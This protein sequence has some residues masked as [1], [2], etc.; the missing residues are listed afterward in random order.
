M[1]YLKWLFSHRWQVITAILALILGSRISCRP[2]WTNIQHGTS[3]VATITRVIEKVKTEVVT[4]EIRVLIPTP[5][6]LKKIENVLGQPIPSGDLL[7]I[8]DIPPSTT[9]Q[10]ATVTLT[11]GVAAVTL[12]PNKEK[13]FQLGGYKWIGAEIGPMFDPNGADY[14]ATIELGANVFKT[15]SIQWYVRAHGDIPIQNPD[16]WEAAVKLGAKRVFP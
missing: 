8:V 6:E 1:I 10:K 11:D 3:S 12:F 5:T 14:E 13:W 4:R 7:T 2:T 15:G 16:R 9:G